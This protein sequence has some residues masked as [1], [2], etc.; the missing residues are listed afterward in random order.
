MTTRIVHV[1]LS[2]LLL[3]TS[4]ILWAAEEKP[5][6]SAKQ[7]D[8]AQMKK[9]C[10]EMMK[11]MDMSKMSAAEHEAMMKRCREMRQQEDAKKKPNQ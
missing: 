8:Q 1:G 6:E 9:R 5:R 4:S 11:D 7:T 3:M 2:A 10:D